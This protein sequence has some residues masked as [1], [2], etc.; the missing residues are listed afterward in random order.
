MSR[1]DEILAQAKARM[2]QSRKK[3]QAIFDR[4]QK[5]IEEEKEKI[6]KG[7][8]QLRKLRGW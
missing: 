2:E 8:E 5:E 3:S 1:K 4:W 7:E 6:R